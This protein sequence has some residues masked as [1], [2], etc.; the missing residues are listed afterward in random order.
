MKTSLLYPGAISHLKASI[1]HAPCDPHMHQQCSGSLPV[2]VEP[3]GFSQMLLCWKQWKHFAIQSNSV[4][5]VLN[6]QLQIL[7][8][9]STI[10]TH[11][12]QP[13]IIWTNLQR[14]VLTI[15]Q[16]RGHHAIIIFLN[17]LKEAQ[18]FRKM[19]I[20]GDIQQQSSFGGLNLSDGSLGKA[21]GVVR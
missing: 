19:G 20:N 6:E 13:S 15:R 8:H 9:C 4:S 11:T 1:K 16:F 5:G 17:F 3:N 18:I 12:T 7:Q 21:K 14:A 2:R 10:P